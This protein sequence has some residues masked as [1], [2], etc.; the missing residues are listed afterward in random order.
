MVWL[1]L[2]FSFEQT[3]VPVLVEFQSL[4]TSD[5]SDSLSMEA[6]DVLVWV[7]WV[8]N[9]STEVW[10]TGWAFV[11]AGESGGWVPFFCGD[12]VVVFAVQTLVTSLTVF[13]G[14]WPAGL[15]VS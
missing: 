3:G 2:E 1:G 14:Q 4:W 5:A 8:F 9:V 12:T 11:W 10:S 13:Q 7:V 15:T 6:S